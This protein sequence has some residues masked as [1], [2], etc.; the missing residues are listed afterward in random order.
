MAF[1]TNGNTLIQI[2]KKTRDKL[3]ET[4]RKGQSYDDI[5]NEFIKDEK[6]EEK[7]EKELDKI[8]EFKSNV[9]TTES[10]IKTIEW[11][12][13]K[14]YGEKC[15]DYDKECIL[16]RIWEVWEQLKKGVKK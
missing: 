7:F 2:S 12:I 15:P 14:D 5:I 1:K 11:H 10:I 9:W 8:C 16:C 13:R 3:K 6:R 4:G